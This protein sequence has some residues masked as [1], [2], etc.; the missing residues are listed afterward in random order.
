MPFFLVRFRALLAD[1]PEIDID[2][3]ECSSR[4]A[5]QAVS[6][7]VADLAV[8]AGQ[9]IPDELEM[10]PLHRDE[11]VLIGSALLGPRKEKPVRLIELL[12]SPP[13]VGLDR[14]N[15][16]H[17]FIDGIARQLGKRLNLRIQVGSFYAVCRMVAAGAGV[18]VVPHI[19]ARQYAVGRLN[20]MQLDESW[21]L[22]DISLLRLRSHKLPGSSEQL[23]SHL[24]DHVQKWCS[25]SYASA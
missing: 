18:A 24:Q 23:I 17:H 6:K 11:L 13:F 19:C 1:R 2:L 9:V 3:E 8:V 12:D 15:S 4:E 7:G 22:R 20:V 21:A 14:H 16:I 25:R 5:A 10:S